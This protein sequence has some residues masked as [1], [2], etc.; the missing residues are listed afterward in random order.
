MAVRNLRGVELPG[1]LQCDVRAGVSANGPRCTRLATWLGEDE[2]G[3]Y[4]Y[5]CNRC[6][7]M[8]E[9]GLYR[10]VKLPRAGEPLESS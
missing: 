3:A 9:G 2:D 8:F 1:K 6:K 10:L 5:L 4:C 7:P